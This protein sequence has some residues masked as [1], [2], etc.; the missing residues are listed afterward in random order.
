MP[1][2]I[3]PRTTIL[4]PDTIAGPTL[5]IGRPW[6]QELLPWPVDMRFTDVDPTV[7]EIERLVDCGR[8]GPPP[9]PS[10]CYGSSA[11]IAT[12][13]RFAEPEIA[14]AAD[15]VVPPT[16]ERLRRGDVR[17]SERQIQDTAGAVGD[18]FITLSLLTRMHADGRIT[19]EEVQAGEQFHSDFRRAALGDLRAAD[20]ARIRGQRHGRELAASTE[21]YR[22][23]VW[24]AVTP[25]GGPTSPCGSIV[26]SVVGEEMDIKRW[27][28]ERFR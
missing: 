16:I 22:W 1:M 13:S 5:G 4:A 10:G 7:L 24:N 2:P 19:L 17:R 23:K 9:A 14:V 21:H 3:P 18:P 15:V 27:C 28:L 20:L 25:L 12:E 8:L 26:W 11:L 6:W